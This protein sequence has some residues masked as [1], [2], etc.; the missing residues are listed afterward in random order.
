MPSK[1]PAVS[2]RKKPIQDRSRATVEAITLAAVHILDE[3]GLDGFNTNAIARR[4][5]VSIGSL[6][7][8]FPNKTAIIG[9]L[10]E[11]QSQSLLRAFERAARAREP[12]EVLSAMIHAYLAQVLETPRASRIIEAERIRLPTDSKVRGYRR[13]MLALVR[14]AVGRIVGYKVDRETAADVYGIVTG[15][16]ATFDLEVGARTMRRKPL[17]ANAGVEARL[18]RVV[19]A[20]VESLQR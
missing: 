13:A 5:G 20:Y 10:I 15:I 6:Y 9:V 12:A 16:V 14:D 17:G 11:Q 4:A 19:S 18:N 2:V 3:R 1:E 7:Q 8:Y